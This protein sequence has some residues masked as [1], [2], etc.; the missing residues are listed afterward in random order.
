M[1]RDYKKTK[2]KDIPWTPATI[3]TYE[4]VQQAL[5]DCQMLYFVDDHSPIY[6]MTDASDYGFGAY[7]C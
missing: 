3:A 5:T 2:Y 4:L 7:C 1:T 6:I